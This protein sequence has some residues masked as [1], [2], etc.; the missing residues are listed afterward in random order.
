MSAQKEDLTK[1]RQE[2]DKIDDKIISLLKD[3]MEIVKEVGKHKLK[4]SATQNFIRAGREADMLRNLTKKIDGKF[5]PAAIATIWRMIISTALCSEQKMSISVYA[6]SDKNDCYWHA[7]EYYGTFV[8]TI[9]ESS[10]EEVIKNVASNKTS[11][12]MLPLIDRSDLPWWDRPQDEHNDIYIF[13]RIPFI[14]SANDDSVPSLAIANVM[15]EATNDDVS[16]ISL[17]SPYTDQE[18]IN[19]FKQVKLNANIIAK[20]RDCH[21]I[22]VDKFIQIGNKVIEDVSTIL[23]SSCVRLMGAYAVPIKL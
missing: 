8:K 12:G 4:N 11:I 10:T 21:L 7:R 18:V 6:D 9:R 19:A 1:Y 17:H 22:Q 13:A 14:E 20:N 3:R 2:I 16:I 15:P 23:A 5:P